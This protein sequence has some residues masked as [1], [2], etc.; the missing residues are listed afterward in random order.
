MED[1]LLIIQKIIEQESKTSTYKFALLRAV[2]DLISA[3][4]PFIEIVGKV[5]KIPVTLISDKWLFYYWDLIGTGYTQIRGERKLAFEERIFSLKSENNFLNYW[6]FNKELH[7]NNYS[8][9]QKKLFSST[10]KELN[11]TII[12]NP[13]RYLGSSSR[14]GE[15][16]FFQIEKNEVKKNKVDGFLDIIENSPKLC[17][18]VAYHDVFKSFGGLI[19]GSNSIILHW[20]TFMNKKIS[21]QDGL[22]VSEP[23]TSYGN[24]RLLSIM[25]QEQVAEREV[26]E[27]RDFW[28]TRIRLGIPVFCAWSGKQIKEV[29]ELAID[30][31]IPFSVMFNNDYWNLLP[32]LSKV[33]GNKSDKILSTNQIQQAKER[34]LDIWNSYKNDPKLSQTFQAHYQISLTGTL[35]VNDLSNLLDKFTSLNE[36]FIDSRGMQ[37][38]EN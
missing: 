31:A 25:I 36:F 26:K 38:W 3:Q 18:D 37:S 2:I 15:Y 7:Q 34:I 6:D 24:D 23:T 12:K 9:A 19:S 29:S 33:N 16:S 30:H 11:N 10:I 14:N 20:I 27:I 4:S 17:F 28:V 5:V 1:K 21:T 35:A 22:I 13:A 32:C 8:E